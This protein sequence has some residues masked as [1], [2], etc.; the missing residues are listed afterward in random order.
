M[1]MISKKE[2]HLQPGQS[3]LIHQHDGK[4]C[5]IEYKVTEG[6]DAGMVKEQQMGPKAFGA[7]F[8]LYYRFS[9]VSRTCQV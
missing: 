9:W 6:P 8:F 5:S 7:L 4:V 3:Y 2:I 1:V